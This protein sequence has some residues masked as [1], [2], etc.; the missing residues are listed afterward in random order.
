[1][2][3]SFV[4]RKHILVLQGTL[5]EELNVFYTTLK[6]NNFFNGT[7]YKDKFEFDEADYGILRFFCSLCIDKAQEAQNGDIKIFPNNTLKPEIIIETLSQL[8]PGE[9]IHVFTNDEVWDIH[10]YNLLKCIWDDCFELLENIFP[11][12]YPGWI[13]FIKRLNKG[14]SEDMEEDDIFTKSAFMSMDISE[15]QKE[16]KLPPNTPF[17]REYQEGVL[18]AW[19][20]YDELIKQP[21]YA[22]VKLKSNIILVTRIIEI[23]KKFNPMIY[24][25]D[26]VKIHIQQYEEMLQGFQMYQESEN[27]RLSEELCD[28]L[29]SQDVNRS[30]NIPQNSLMKTFNQVDSYHHETDEEYNYSIV[31]VGYLYRLEPGYKTGCTIINQ[32]IICKMVSSIHV[33]KIMEYF[34][35]FH[36]H[37]KY[38]NLQLEYIKNIIDGLNE[39]IRSYHDNNMDVDRLMGALKNEFRDFYYNKIKETHIFEI[40]FYEESIERYNDSSMISSILKELLIREKSLENHKDYCDGCNE[41]L[42][43]IKRLILRYKDLSTSIENEDVLEIQYNIIKRKMDNLIVKKIFP[44]NLRK[45]KSLILSYKE[46][47][48][49]FH[50]TYVSDN[51]SNYAINWIKELNDI[52]PF[53]NVIPDVMRTEIPQISVIKQEVEQMRLYYNRNYTFKSKMIK[54]ILEDIRILRLEASEYHEP[55]CSEMIKKLR[56]AERGKVHKTSEILIKHTNEDYQLS[57]NMK[58]YLDKNICPYFMFVTKPIGY[59]NNKIQVE[60]TGTR[61]NIEMEDIKTFLSKNLIVCYNGQEYFIP[62]YNKGMVKCAFQTDMKCNKVLTCGSCIPLLQ[63]VTK[64]E[65]RKSL[66]VHDGYMCSSYFVREVGNPNTHIMV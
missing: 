12:Y 61:I 9:Y 62:F 46:Q 3:I 38:K 26:E 15:Q 48:T 53:N 8:Y 27:E 25:E 65:I 55:F 28:K 36:N 54:L 50:S 14:K 17:L 32:T 60:Y 42:N 29:I 52:I 11:K 66:V 41:V 56:I 10:E 39:L 33:K 35:A 13:K 4:D 59:I 44:N 7:V 43:K 34:L 18:K 40:G 23:L 2:L 22:R 49:L 5:S 20:E 45:L 64:E 21:D 47:W 31:S 19:S 58:H 37:I 57:S 30:V 6:N 51:G 63:N 16:L 24:T 1:M